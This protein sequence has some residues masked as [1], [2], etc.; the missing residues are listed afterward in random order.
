[1]AERYKTTVC[2]LVTL[3]LCFCSRSYNVLADVRDNVEHNQIIK[4]SEGVRRIAAVQYGLTHALMTG[5]RN[6]A[7]KP[8]DTLLMAAA[9]RKATPGGPRYR[10]SK[11]STSTDDQS[12]VRRDVIDLLEQLKILKLVI[13]ASVRAME[14]ANATGEWIHSP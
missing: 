9:A 2:Y 14:P 8:Q 4:D 6:A 5:Y 7:A 1:M 3:T 11:S 13:R 10:L 12:T